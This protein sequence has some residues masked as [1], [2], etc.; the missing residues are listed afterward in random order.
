MESK[1][2]VK[3]GLLGDI[4]VVKGSKVLLNQCLRVL[5]IAT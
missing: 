2:S 4:C 1:S 3:I 5:M